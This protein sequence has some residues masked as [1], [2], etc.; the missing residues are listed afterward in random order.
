MRRLGLSCLLAFAIACRSSSES[1]AKG[2]VEQFYAA[3]L[4][5]RVTGA[6]TTPQLAALAPFL[7]DTLHS[8]LAAARQRSDAEAARDPNEKP[9]FADGD[10]FSSLFEGPN[11]V[12]VIA[13]SARGAI[14]VA[15]VRMTST[16]ATPPLTWV[17]RV[18]LT[19]RDGDYVIDDVEYGGTWDF[20]NRGN[21]R[22]TLA[23]ALAAPP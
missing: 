4:E 8:L 16:G 14:Q 21:L 23:A 9:S 12:E 19:K 3:T 20:A 2:V 5:Q 18:L 13:D 22:A 15:T 11:A 6:P 7:S 17:D 10:L 1:N